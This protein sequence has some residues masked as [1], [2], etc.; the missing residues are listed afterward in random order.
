MPVAAAAAPAGVIAD[1]AAPPATIESMSFF[2]PINAR[3][4][5]SSRGI[6]SAARTN[7]EEF[8]MG[9]A[10]ILTG[11]LV[12]LVVNVMHAATDQLSSR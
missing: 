2:A 4:V 6:S 5:H 9:L 1:S 12:A 3:F 11:C 7:K 10:N 8:A